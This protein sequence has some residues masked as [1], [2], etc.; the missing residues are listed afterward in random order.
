MSAIEELREKA[1][2][3]PLKPGVYIMMDE[4]GEVIYVGKAKQLKNRVSSYFHGAHNTKTEAMISRIA[5]FDIIIANTEF[6]ALVLENSLIKHHM[7]K[8]NILLKDD[9]GYPFIRID[10]KSEYP[11]FSV[12]HETAR[13]GAAYFGP[14]G[15]RGSTFSVIDSIRKAL[16]LPTCKKNFPA[17]I[18]KARPCLNHHLGA[19]KAYCLKDT[20]ASDYRAAID[21]AVMILEGKMSKL[22]KTLTSEMNEAAENYKF[23]LAAEKRDR[24]RALELLG[25]RQHVW[26]TENAELDIVGFYR[27]ESKSAFVVLHCIEGKLLDK[28]LNIFET[29][30][31]EDADAVTS[32]VQQYYN[33]RGVIPR[34]VLIPGGDAQPLSELLSEKAGRKVAVLIPERGNKRKLI[35]TANMNAREEVI[36]ITTREEKIS[37]TAEWLRVN[38]NLEKSPDRIESFDISNTGASDIVASMVVFQKGR[39]LKKDYR[40]F[41]IKTTDGQDDYGSMTEVVARRL[42]RYKSGDE[43]FGILPDIFLIDGGTTHAAAAKRVVDEMGLNIPVFG[44]VKDDRHRTRALVTPEGDEIGIAAQPSVFAFIGTIQEETHRFAIEFHRASRKKS[45]LKSKLDTIPGVGE[46]RKNALLKSF[47]TVKA[48][49]NASVEE[50]SKVVPKTAAQAVYESFR[51]ESGE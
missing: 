9:K 37:R 7:P 48:I 50:L 3:L 17:D 23:E 6:E 34:T 47:K 24:I 29:P 15:G 36:R 26:T 49:S 45:T 8:Y 25:T 1:N 51:K 16:K 20:P 41:K 14:F 38:L 33:M 11:T 21:E 19:C 13:D 32:L 31:Q 2:K 43:K 42:A 46:A 4:H 40:K 35:E 10:I 30:M 12:V 27:G 22:I 5:R 18:G 28:D 39:P 44:M